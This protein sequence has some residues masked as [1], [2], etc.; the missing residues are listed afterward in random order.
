MGQGKMA[1][2]QAS[3][4]RVLVISGET[5]HRKTLAAAV[6]QAG[7]IPSACATA[8][9]AK[10]FLAGERYA[11]VLCEDVLPDGDFRSVIVQVR[12]LAGATPVIV[13]SRR[14]DWDSCMIALA[15]GAADYVAFPPNPGEVERSLAAVAK[16]SPEF[17]NVA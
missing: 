9:E 2:H 15:A 1:K 3:F 6:E 14:D 16:F 11:A 13:V 8:D 7:W 4:E 17:A 5:R 12:R 10:L